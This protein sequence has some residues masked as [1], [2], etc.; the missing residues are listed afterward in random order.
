M[1][2]ME[3]EDAYAAFLYCCKRNDKTACACLVS[4]KRRGVDLQN[5]RDPH[6]NNLLHA[7]V[8]R[9]C[10]QSAGLLVGYGLTTGTLN[11]NAKSAMQLA[12]DY[13]VY[14]AGYRKTFELLKEAPTAGVSAAEVPWYRLRS[15]KPSQCSPTADWRCGGVVVDGRGGW[16]GAGCSRRYRA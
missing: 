16:I 3:L 12:D 2:T 4:L 7:A 6:G 8:S 15:Q 9:G 14:G 10:C 13:R 11:N 5:A 1:G